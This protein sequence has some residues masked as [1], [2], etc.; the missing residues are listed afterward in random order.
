MATPPE[1][2]L[3]VKVGIAPTAT[4]CVC[5]LKVMVADAASVG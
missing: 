5:G 3:I 4:D 2:M 1:L